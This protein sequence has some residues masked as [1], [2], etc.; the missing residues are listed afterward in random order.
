MTAP[1]NV[2][3]ASRAV[4]AHRRHQSLRAFTLVEVILAVLIISGIMT[5]LLFFYQRSAET[6]Q[7]A[8]EEAEFL[9]VSRRFLEQLTTELR[10][11]RALA[12]SSGQFEAGSNFVSF[13]C[14][15]YPR[16]SRWIVSTNESIQLPAVS[17]LRRV[18]YQ[19]LAS[20]SNTGNASN[21]VPR[22]LERHE[23]ALLGSAFSAGTNATEIFSSTETNPAPTLLSSPLAG[24]ATLALSAASPENPAILPAGTNLAQHGPSPLT[25]RIRHLRFR[26][27]SRTNW[28]ESW[29]GSD[30]PG[31]VEVTLGRDPMPLDS[32]SY[33]YEIFRRV[34]FIP[35]SA[36]PGNRVDVAQPGEAGL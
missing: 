18:R 26:F 31:G 34:I 30:L 33:P 23:E 27:W 28:V 10:A 32:E 16:V 14:T 5:V 35:Q 36:D 2:L 20:P 24:T 9:A 29:S 21:A 19:L 12:D 6:R 17:D 15:T 4:K 13:V 25:D 1:S 11:S 3:R 7:A 22:G 8:L